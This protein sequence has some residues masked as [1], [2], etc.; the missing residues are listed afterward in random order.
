VFEDGKLVKTLQGPTMKDDF[1]K[2]V[3]VYVEKKYGKE[4][5]RAVA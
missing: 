4:K 3:Q 2:M 5:A 1:K